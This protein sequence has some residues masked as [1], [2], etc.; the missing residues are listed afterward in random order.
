MRNCLDTVDHNQVMKKFGHGKKSI[1]MGPHCGWGRIKHGSAEKNH[2][3]KVDVFTCFYQFH[4][5]FD[6]H[7]KH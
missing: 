1:L 3:M 6:V 2:K 5:H 7:N 4:F